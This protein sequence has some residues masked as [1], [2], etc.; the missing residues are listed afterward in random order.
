M[1]IGEIEYDHLATGDSSDL[2]RIDIVPAGRVRSEQSTE[3]KARR[4]QFEV[5]A[6]WKKQQA[7][8]NYSGAEEQ[9]SNPVYRIAFSSRKR[10]DSKPSAREQQQQVSA[11]VR[12]EYQFQFAGHDIPNRK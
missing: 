10:T 9:N 8:D 6:A 12:S 5:C 7:E 3:R 1:Q 11:S 4:I 2:E